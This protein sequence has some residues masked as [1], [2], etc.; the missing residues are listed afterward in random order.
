TEAERIRAAEEENVLFSIEQL[1]GYAGVARKLQEGSLRL[2][3]WFFK[4][5]TAE[6]FGYDPEHRQF[7]L[8]TTDTANLPAN[9]ATQPTPQL[10]LRL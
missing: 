2:H 4:I 1:H 10:P 5:D 3:A 9:G 6:L 7:Q 8:I